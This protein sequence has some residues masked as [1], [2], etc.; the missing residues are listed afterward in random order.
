MTLGVIS[1]THGDRAA[2][3]R[4]MAAAGEVDGWIHL[5]DHYRDAAILKESGCEVFAVAG[6]CDY[7]GESELVLGVVGTKLLLTHG[8]MY[9]VAFSLDK[10]CYRAEELGCSAALFG[11]THIQLLEEGGEVLLLNPGSPSRPRGGSRPGY[12]LLYIG[13]DGSLDADLMG[14]HMED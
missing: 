4:A 3:R 2:I 12:A 11:H 1:D 8:H 14:L 5:G 6:N 7:G 13:E 10:L 9:G